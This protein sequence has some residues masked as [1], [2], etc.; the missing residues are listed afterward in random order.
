MSQKNIAIR[1]EHNRIWIGPESNVQQ[2]KHR[3]AYVGT[4]IGLEQELE[5]D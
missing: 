2:G 5:M 3:N 1:Q 4:R